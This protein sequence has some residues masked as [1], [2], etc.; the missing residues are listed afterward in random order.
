LTPYSFLIA[1]FLAA[2]I[3]VS[4]R[5]QSSREVAPL[6]SVLP[7]D[8]L[9]DLPSTDSLFSTLETTHAPVVSDRFSAGLNPAEPA[10][11]GAFL[12]SWNQT[13]FRIDDVDITSPQGGVPMFVPPIA[14]WQM[15]AVTSGLAPAD[16]TGPG[17]L[18]SLSPRRPSPTWS[19]SGM[20]AGSRNPFV[21]AASNRA[22]AIARPDAWS[23]ASVVFGGPVVPDRAGLL[24]AASTTRS[25]QFERG[26]SVAA[27]AGIDSLFAHLIIGLGNG[28][29]RTVGWLQAARSPLS[30]D[31][32]YVQPGSLK[33]DSS[34]HLQAT[35]A[36]SIPLHATWRIFAAVTQRDRDTTLSLTPSPT[37]ERLIDGPASDLGGPVPGVERRWTVGVRAEEIS[38]Q[39]LGFTHLFQAGVDG[40]AGQVRTN[41]TD[42]VT[43]RELVAGM[44]ARVWNYSGTGA[45][46]RSNR[47]L[48]GYLSDRIALTQRV[49]L[50][51][52]IRFDSVAGRA[53]G[54]TEHIAWNSWLPRAAVRWHVSDAGRV[55]VFTAYSRTADV[56]SLA[57][58]AY[59]DPASSVSEVQRW[60]GTAAGPVVALAGPGAGPNLTLTTIDPGTRRPITE[61]FAVGFELT[62]NAWPRLR[63]TSV[64]K[65]ASQQLALV[66]IGVPASSYTVSFL[67]DPGPSLSDPVDDQMLPIYNRLPESF[68]RDRY[69]LTNPQQSDATF[70]GMTFNADGSWNRTFLSAGATMG[71]TMGLAGNRGFGP[72]ENDLG[73]VGELFADPNAATHARGNLFSD[74]Q[75]TVKIAGVYR[76]GHE[77]RVGAIARY[78]DGQAFSR[79]VIVPDLNQG[80]E[81]IR[82]FRS[83]KSRFTY[84]GTLDVRVQKGVVLPGSRRMVLFIDAY[85]VVNMAKEVEEWVA[86]GPAFRTPTAVQPPRAIHVGLR[87]LL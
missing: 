63:F 66:N 6:T 30:H 34:Q 53:R 83:G 65:R 76:F 22:P 70:R 58:L 87:L 31:L 37:V 1:A 67:P 14:L 50:D 16:V 52:T 32:P 78:Q 51:A 35:W 13:T 61:E 25:S 56:L 42:P 21:A 86:T 72:S 43:V 9:Q 60:N 19:A 77:V 44:P 80:T 41:A 59:G 2:L 8:A 55:S 54:A 24:M 20:V 27:D 26:N 4:A 71:W 17:V 73:I 38:K 40:K 82:A 46:Y 62:P 75:Y 23:H 57:V 68:G 29:L 10:R 5:A 47:E 33:R 28:E 81:A 11:L 79:M 64:R 84:T 15:V 45:G 85:N 49:T 74:R 36:R 12:S 18:V 3:S 39:A 69:V 48:A 7:A